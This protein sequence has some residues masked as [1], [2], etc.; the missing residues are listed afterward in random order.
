LQR[1]EQELDQLEKNP[2]RQARAVRLSNWFTRYYTFIVQ[3]NIIINAAISSAGGNWLG[4]RKT[5]YREYAHQQR[6]H[7]M[8]YESDPATPRQEGAD[9]SLQPLPRWPAIIRLLHCMGFPGLRAYY[10]EVREWFRDNNMRLFYR[11]HYALKGSAWLEPYGYLRGKQGTFWQDGEALN[12]KGQGFVI[13]P[14][15]AEGVLGKDILLLDTLK[16]GDYD[17][18][19]AARAVIA[20]SGGRL[21]HGAT[22]LRELQKP[23]A[24][25]PDVDTSLL[26]SH[27]RFSQGKIQLL[28]ESKPV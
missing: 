10:T 9:T 21:S 14:G 17:N 5:I 1:F 4:G 6:L 28:K 26:G 25:I 3:S 24:I 27:V 20:R 8:P 11:L 2:D 12:E 23:S 18:F 19:A 22:L 15:E 7:R 13:C 16:A